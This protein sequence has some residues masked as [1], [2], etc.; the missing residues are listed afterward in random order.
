MVEFWEDGALDALHVIDE[1][2]GPIDFDIDEDVA[3]GHVA[4]LVAGMRSAANSEE[5]DERFLVDELVQVGAYA[6]RVCFQADIVLKDILELLIRK[7]HAYGRGNILAFGLT[8]LHVRVSDK[9]ARIDNLR[10]RDCDW[11][12]K[13]DSWIDLVGYAVI[14][15]M[16]RSETFDLPLK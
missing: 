3:L 5:W 13:L 7:Q 9:V 6:L 11:E 14:A 2:C 10:G 15:E 12:S 4:S 8:G 1:A 16:L